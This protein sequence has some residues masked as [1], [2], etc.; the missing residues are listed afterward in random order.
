[1]AI[2]YVTEQA[3]IL[4]KHQSVPRNC[5]SGSVFGFQKHSEML[6]KS[7][8]HGQTSTQFISAVIVPENLQTGK[9]TRRTI[10]LNYSESE[11]SLTSQRP[12]RGTT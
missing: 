10:R 9:D 1:M 3:R 12:E 5:A 8:T 6:L 11:A 7:K 4:N 2:S